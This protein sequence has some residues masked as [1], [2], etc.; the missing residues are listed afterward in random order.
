M[1]NPQDPARDEEPDPDATMV[2]PRR[3][4]ALQPPPSAPE[5]PTAPD[6]PV[7]GAE[8]SLIAGSA[9]PPPETKTGP[10][11]GI[12]AAPPP[13][14]APSRRAA[15]RAPPPIA[16]QPGPPLARLVA[17]PARFE[18]EQAATLLAPDGDMLRLEFRSQARLGLPNGEVAAVDAEA[19]RI[20]ATTFGLIGPGGVLPRHYTATVATELRKRSGALHAFLDLLAR[21]F[22]A[23]WIEAGAKYRPT[24]NPDPA[25]R[26]L[27]A[28]AGLGTPHMAERLASPLPAVLF[29]AGNLSART[30]S[31]ERLRALLEEEAACAVAIVEFDGGWLRVP[32][33]ERTRLPS[34][35]GPHGQGRLGMDAMAGAAVYDP[36]SRIRIRLGPLSAARFAEFLPGRPLHRRLAELTRLFLGPEMEFVFNP[37]LRAA[38]V[39]TAALGATAR[40]G[41][42]SWVAPPAPRRQD[43]DDAVLAPAG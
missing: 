23:R 5:P 16:P 34:R 13:A 22:T 7:P 38:D 25:T 21:R 40:L 8:P 26:A 29:H 27:A 43:A 30:R 2:A 24:R 37:V 9:P 18:L 20:T 36:Q 10:V 42:T 4:A 17:E 31:A 39:P 1:S 14:T 15:P 11:A 28:A 32:D 3:T 35:S 41:W 19:G 33:T 6:D 12:A